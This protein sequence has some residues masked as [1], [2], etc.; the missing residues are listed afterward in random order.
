MAILRNTPKNSTFP[1]FNWKAGVN[2][3]SPF[4]LDG[5]DGVAPIHKC[6][7]EHRAVVVDV[8]DGGAIGGDG[9]GVGAFEIPE[10]FVQTGVAEVAVGIVGVFDFSAAQAGVSVGMNAFGFAACRGGN[11]TIR[12]AAGVIVPGPVDIDIAVTYNKPATI[13]LSVFGIAGRVSGIS[14]VANSSIASCAV[15]VSR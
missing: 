8:E 14:S 13:N 5:F 11:L 6:Q 3:R 9:Y 4:G 15:S 7:R 10:V 1:L 12:K 2:I